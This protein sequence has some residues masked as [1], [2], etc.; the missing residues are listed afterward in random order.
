MYW[1]GLRVFDFL[2]GGWPY[3]A[4]AKIMGGADHFEK[5]SPAAR[6]SY[7]FSIIFKKKSPAA[8]TFFIQKAY[9]HHICYVY[10]MYNHILYYSAL[11]I[12]NTSNKLCL[13]GA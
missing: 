6:F 11:H 8:G 4:S 2:G 1:G 7:I 5:F 9:F 13:L 12:I 10:L 3:W